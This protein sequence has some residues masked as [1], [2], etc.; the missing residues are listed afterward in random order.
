M[1]IERNSVFISAF[2]LFLFSTK[3]MAIGDATGGCVA[4][5]IENSPLLKAAAFGA[6]ADVMREVE[7]EIEVASKNVNLQT[8]L[9]FSLSKNFRD[10]WRAKKQTEIVN[11]PMKCT[12]EWIL[13][14]AVAAGN[15]SVVR[16]LLDVG[17][18]PNAK[19]LEGNI[20]TRCIKDPTLNGLG[21]YSTDS[22]GNIKRLEALDLILSRGGDLKQTHSALYACKDLEVVSFYILR[23]ANL[24]P[25]TE[26]DKKFYP[27]Q[28]AVN[29]ALMGDAW[30]KGLERIKV[31]AKHGANDI[32]GLHIEGVLRIKCKQSAYEA[33]CSEIQKHVNSSPGTFASGK[34]KTKFG[35]ILYDEFNP[36]RETCEFP[37]IGFMSD[38]SA[39]AVHLTPSPQLSKYRV[40]INNKL[41]DAFVVDV[42][43][44]S[45]LRPIF[46]LLTY[47][48]GPIFWRFSRTQNTKIMAVA[49]S[50]LYD[51]QHFIGG[52]DESTII[53][54]NC[55]ITFEYQKVLEVYGGSSGD[56]AL[57]PFR[58]ALK[59]IYFSSS[60]PI[61]IG[62]TIKDVEKV[63]SSRVFNSVQSYKNSNPLNLEVLEKK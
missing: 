6:P 47:N 15:V 27:L 59:N 24:S 1:K 45:P 8:R 28:L 21:K 29:D 20:F 34:Y 26:F 30:K 63:I 61:N 54:D 57:N 14:Y 23:G 42:I 43:V 39:V 35:K 56:A 38:F 49:V 2:I 9:R 18:N 50:S 17:A 52:L 53:L 7:A 37:E 22:V 25:P 33:V 46:I 4:P 13:D 62:G 44:D 40:K 51:T 10:E 12:N 58:T 19:S 16:W 11:S 3:A 31:F 55:G 36:R 60:S 32:R 41:S 48:S 5:T